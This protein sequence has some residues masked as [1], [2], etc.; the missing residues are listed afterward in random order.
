VTARAHLADLI[1]R[2]FTDPERIHQVQAD[3]A[4][5]IGWH[6]RSGVI[7]ADTRIRLAYSVNGYLDMGGLVSRLDI[8]RRGY[9]GL[10]LGVASP[11]WRDELRMPLIQDAVAQRYARPVTDVSVGVQQLDGT[12]LATHTFSLPEIAAARDRFRQL[13]D[14]VRP[15]V[16]TI[17]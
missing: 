10:L 9:D 11:T 7:V 1:R 15:F 4:A 16:P 14:N 3:L 12:N 17:P 13:G 6:H 8:T 2:H 5:Y